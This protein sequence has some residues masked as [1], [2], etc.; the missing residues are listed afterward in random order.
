MLC[1]NWDHQG[2]SSCFARSLPFSFSVCGAKHNCERR[3]VKGER[4]EGRRSV[5]ARDLVWKPHSDRWRYRGAAAVWT[6]RTR[7]RAL[8]H[9]EGIRSTW[10]RGRA[11]AGARAV[12]TGAGAPVGCGCIALCLSGESLPSGRGE[13]NRRALRNRHR[14]STERYGGNALASIFGNS[15]SA[16]L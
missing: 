5:R 13:W 2:Q 7:V 3:K 11:R 1:E 10:S 16:F 4:E 9:P 15:R 14:G 6:A 12:Q 8:P